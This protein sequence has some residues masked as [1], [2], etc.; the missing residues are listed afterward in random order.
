[1]NNLSLRALR[2][3]AAAAQHK[4]ISAAAKRLHISP[5]SI[6]VAITDLESALGIQLFVRQPSRGMRLTPAGERVFTEAMALLGHVDEF[7]S[8]AG[9]LGHSVQGELSVACFTNLAP[10]YFS[11]LLAQFCR[12]YPSVSINL[13]VGDHE[14][15]LSGLVGGQYELA[16]T[17]NLRIPDKFEWLLLAE[18]PPNIVLPIGHRLANAERV[19]LRKMVTEPLILMDLPHTRDYFLSLFF[20]LRLQP[21]V[22]FRS[23]NFEMVRTLVGNEL[24]YSVLNLV[25]QSSTTYDGTRIRYLPIAEKVRPLQIGCL[26]VKRIAQRQVVKAFT[27]F[28]RA[29]FLKAFSQAPNTSAKRRH[30]RTNDRDA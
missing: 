30:R 2:Y 20:G 21:N 22:R 29:Y 10:V 1:M 24:G 9:A 28:S 13:H 18:V 14:E 27:D 7:Q 12:H 16:L 5:A 17:F 4:A 23:T 8:L 19:S 6:S 25:P 3:F 26:S 15:I 11:N